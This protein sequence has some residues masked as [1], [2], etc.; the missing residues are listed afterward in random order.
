MPPFQF[1]AVI[2]AQGK[3]VN[4]V[5]QFLKATKD[6]IQA[7]P[8]TVLG[9]A[10]APLPRKA[11]QHRMQ[12]LIK[13]PSRKVLKSSLTQLREWL[14]MNKLSNGIRWNVDVDPMDLS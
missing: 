4:K 1:L 14:T 12:L 5:D 9:P 2:R 8:L 6:Q 3:T 7:H 10:P 13:S 11:N